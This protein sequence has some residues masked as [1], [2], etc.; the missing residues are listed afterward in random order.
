MTK[1]D[2]LE[3]KKVPNSD[4]NIKIKFSEDNLNCKDKDTN[5]WNFKEDDL[6]VYN[7]DYNQHIKKYFKFKQGDSALIYTDEEAINKQRGILQYILKRIGTNLLS[8]TGI[9]NISLPIRIFD[10]RSL[11]EVFACQLAL[12]PYFLEKAGLAKSPIERLKYVI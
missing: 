12:S 3:E 4:I 7:K 5:T 1:L 2:D 10:E 11:L 8:G 9:M 6:I